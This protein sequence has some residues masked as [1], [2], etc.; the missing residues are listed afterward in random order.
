MGLKLSFEKIMQKDDSNRVTRAE[1]SITQ[2]ASEIALRVTQ[3]TFNALQGRVE[4]TESSLILQANQ[5][6]SKVSQTTHNA[7]ANR[8]SSAESSIVQ[9][10]SQITSKVSTTDYT[11]ATIASKINQ[12]SSTVKVESQHIK[13]EGL[14]TANSNFKVLLDGSVET[15]GA[16]ISGGRHVLNSSGFT[17]RDSNNNIIVS[18]ANG[19]ANEQN[20]GRADNVESGYPMKLPFH[21]GEE[22]NQIVQAKLKWDISP[23]RTYSKGAASGGGTKTTPS[24]GAGTT[25]TRWGATGIAVGTSGTT[26]SAGLPHNHTVSLDDLSH[27]HST[28]SHTHSMDITHEHA[29]VFGILEASVASN[30]FSIYVDGVLRTSVEAQRGEVDLSAWITTSGW[31]TIEL[32]V[33]SMKRIDAN[34]FLKTYIRR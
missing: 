2:L 18:S 9:Q 14:V 15:T 22:V 5:I 34:L 25:G 6:E 19:V 12:S 30:W 28:P 24:G 7:L 21:I 13:L 11:G 4:N 23:F 20:I 27:N 26:A 29:P 1:S 3:Q 32:R 17:L 16:S 33:T 10:A 31:H 8:V